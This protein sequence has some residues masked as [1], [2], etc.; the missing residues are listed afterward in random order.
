MSVGRCGARALAGAWRTAAQRQRWGGT[1]GGTAGAAVA[2]GAGHARGFGLYDEMLAMA[3]R[4][5]TAQASRRRVPDSIVAP[6]YALTGT[7]SAKLPKAAWMIEQHSDEDIELARV[8]GRVSR[9]VL[10]EAGRAVAAGVTTEEIDRIVHEAT[11]KRGAY[12]SPLNYHGFPRS[13]CTSI[14]EVVCHGIPEKR[15]LREGDI[16]NIDVSCYIGGFHG[17]NSEMFCVGEVDD[18][19][20]KLIQVQLAARAHAR[21]GRAH[22]D[23]RQPDQRLSP[24][25][26]DLIRRASAF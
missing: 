16:L 17:D 14:N 11:I 25:S 20:K 15:T 9:E 3:G 6:D 22:K 21:Q 2:G 13:V 12:P 8:A 26:P 24:S 5:N 4:M 10:D 19:A 18:A 7:P 1:G 23:A